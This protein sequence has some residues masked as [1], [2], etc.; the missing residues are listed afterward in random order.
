MSNSLEQLKATGTVSTYSG[1]G[2]V[3]EVPTVNNFTTPPP[4]LDLHRDLENDC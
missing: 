4:T 1:F 3:V 2:G